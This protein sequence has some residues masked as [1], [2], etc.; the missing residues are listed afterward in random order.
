MTAELQAKDYERTAVLY[1]AME[2]SDAK[3]RLAF[4]EGTRQR[5]VGIA[6]GDMAGRLEPV[7]KAKAKWGLELEA[8][9]VSGYEAGRDGFWRHRQ[10][11]ALGIAN[12]VVD[13]ASIEVSRR[14]RRAKTD[15]LEA[16]ARL[17]KSI[18]YEQ[19]ERGVWREVRVP[20]VAWEDPSSSFP[21]TLTPFPSPGGRGAMAPF[22]RWGKGWG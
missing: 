5:Q 3:W 9:T 10:R 13:A 14:A 1:R 4:G 20:A 17:G 2:R 18:R 6:A 7:G 16:R 21:P 22:P 15:R 12:R 8:R 11:L 19:G